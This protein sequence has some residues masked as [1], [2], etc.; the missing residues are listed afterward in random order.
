MKSKL[1][2]EEFMQVNI[3]GDIVS[4]EHGVKADYGQFGEI[5]GGLKVRGGDLDVCRGRTCGNIDGG[6]LRTYYDRYSTHLSLEEYDDNV[7]Y[8]L[9]T[10]KN[11][12]KAEITKTRNG[13]VY[14]KNNNGK[15]L[16]LQPNGDLCLNGSCVNEQ[17][18]KNLKNAIKYTDPVV[19]S[20]EKTTHK[21]SNCG[22]YGCRV[23]KRGNFA[24]YNGGNGGNQIE[25]HHG[26][27]NPQE[28][29]LQRPK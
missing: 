13:T 1:F 3:P 17:D 22:W 8:E 12:N 10:N 6:R 29:Y 21:T 14:I 16:S 28:F 4:K 9:K 23:A 18:F 27:N 24:G 11:N 25:F 26:G 2:T 5:R 19:I 20:G 7:S 15:T